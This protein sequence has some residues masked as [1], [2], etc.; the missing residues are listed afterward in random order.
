MVGIPHRLLLPSLPTVGGSA[1]S[2]FERLRT[3]PL[4]GG[5]HALFLGEEASLL[6]RLHDVLFLGGPAFQAELLG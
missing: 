4:T 6:T 3:L 1:L 5:R 2:F